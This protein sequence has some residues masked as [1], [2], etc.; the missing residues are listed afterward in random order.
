MK[1]VDGMFIKKSV[2]TIIFVCLL[3]APALMVTRHKADN[4]IAMTAEEKEASL[5]TYGLYLEDVTKSTGVDFEHLSPDLDSK[6]KPILP[7]IASMGASVAVCDFD[8]D[9]WNDFYCTNSRTG[10]LNAL[11]HNQHDGTFRD[12]AGPMNVA[13]AN[14][15]GTGVSMGAVWGDYDNDGYEDLFVY[16]WGKCE[17]YH[18]NEGKSFTNVTGNTGLPGWINANTA[19]WFD[20]N[21]DGYADLFIGCYYPETVNL[22]HLKTTVIMPESFEYANNGG[23]NYLMKNNGDGTFSDVTLQSGLTSTKWTLAC[24][25]LDINRDGYQD[26]VVANDYSVDEI[27]LNE[28]GKSFKEAGRQMGIGYS[29]KSGMNVSFGDVDNSGNLGIYISNITEMGVLLQGNNFWVPEKKG[30]GIVYENRA[31]EK[32]VELGGWSYGTQFGDLNNDGSQDI[33][34]ANGFI[35]GK[36]GTSYWY[37]YSKVTGGNKSIIS[38][39]KN[40]PDMKGRSQSGYQENIIWLNDGQGNFQEAEDRISPRFTYDS[41]SVAFADLWNRGVIDVIVSSQNNRLIILKNTVTPANGWIDFE[42][43]GTKSNRSAIGAIIDLY[44]NGK[45]QSQVVTAGIGFCAENQRRIHFGI[46]ASK[47]IDKAVIHWPSGV[48]QTIMNPKPDMLHKIT[49]S[50]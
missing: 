26:L 21:N 43:Y 1:I 35:S 39:V 28:G 38:D 37:D 11:Y 50:I 42:L 34:T 4:E 29:P 49:E 31:R 18:N 9:G 12:V 33:Y 17:L 36:K 30:N 25:A 8:N 3:A 10:T 47:N 19:I 46:G 13:K 40:W 41:R 27:F 2:V 32:G 7:Q 14:E 48:E 22:W 16:K 6:L 15:S 45:K 5:R 23:R 24:G 44:W 20:Y